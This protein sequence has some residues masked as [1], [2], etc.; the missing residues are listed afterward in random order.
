MR[1]EVDMDKII[2]KEKAKEEREIREK[3]EAK[4]QEEKRIR[5]GKSGK[6]DPKHNFVSYCKWCQTEYE[7]QFA[8]CNRCGKNTIDKETRLKELMEKVTIMKGLKKHKLERKARWENYLKTQSLLYNKMSNNYKKWEY[9]ESESEEEEEKPFIPPEND[10]NFRGFYL[11]YIFI[12]I[13]ALEKDITERGERKKKAR[14]ES[15]ALKVKGN[16]YMTKGK[17]KAAVKKYTQ[18]IELCKD[19]FILYTNRSLANLKQEKFE[20]I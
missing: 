12:Y 10:P 11:I 6:G 1:G 9:F 14:K 16:N 4:M 2:A 7:V 18:A 17:Y 3:E 13:L 8:K 20:V 5:E 15:E 19:Y